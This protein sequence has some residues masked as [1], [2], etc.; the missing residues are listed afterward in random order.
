M[1]IRLWPGRETVR[2]TDISFTRQDRIPDE[3]GWDDFPRYAPDLTVEV[4]SPFE[5]PA[6]V[7]DRIAMFLQAGTQIT[8]LV[9]LK[10]KTVMVFHS[11]IAP[12]MFKEGDILEGGDALPA[13]SIP[14]AEIF[15]ERG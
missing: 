9:D 1:R 5:R 12:T 4:F 2:V 11:E 3:R 6:T 14:V 8:W 7:V 10:R 13:F 15:A